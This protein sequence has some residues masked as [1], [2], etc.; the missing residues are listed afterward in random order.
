VYPLSLA[1]KN[2]IIPLVQKNASEV[3]LSTVPI[4]SAVNYSVRQVLLLTYSKIKTFSF[5][6]T[7]DP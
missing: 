1:E 6:V 5:S 7:T 4:V 2:K 3:T